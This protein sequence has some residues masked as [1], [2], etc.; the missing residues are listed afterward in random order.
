MNDYEGFIPRW[1]TRRNNEQIDIYT[2]NDPTREHGVK[3]ALTC[4]VSTPI[5]ESNLW[6]EIQVCVC[7]DTDSRIYRR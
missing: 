5:F 6:V 3:N 2:P 4:F 1:V 7:L